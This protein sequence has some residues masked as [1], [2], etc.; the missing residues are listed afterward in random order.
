MPQNE[1]KFIRREIKK[2][3]KKYLKGNTVHVSSWI[4]KT[5]KGPVKKT[6]TYIKP[7]EDGA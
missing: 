2:V 7:K 1:F 3:L 4:E 6:S 5:L